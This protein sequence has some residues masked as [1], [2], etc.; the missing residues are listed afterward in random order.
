M[1]SK[2]VLVSQGQIV[3]VNQSAVLTFTPSAAFLPQTDIVFFALGSEKFISSQVVIQLKDELLNYVSLRTE[4]LSL[5][6][7]QAS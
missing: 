6:T 7:L 2:D 3:F 4:E 1:M 5:F